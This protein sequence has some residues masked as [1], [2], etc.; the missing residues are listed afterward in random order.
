M[1]F[2]C[3]EASPTAIAVMGCTGGLLW[4][5]PGP[6][7]TV[8]LEKAQDPLFVENLSIFLAD[9][10]RAVFSHTMPETIKG[11]RGVPRQTDPADP[12]H[13]TGLLAGILHGIGHPDGA[14]YRIQKRVR[15]DVL[16]KDEG[17]PWRRSPLWLVLRVALQTT[18]RHNDICLYKAFMVFFMTEMVKRADAEHLDSD[19]LFLMNAKLGRR[20][21]KASTTLPDFVFEEAREVMLR[22]QQTL[23]NRWNGIQ[24]DQISTDRW[25]PKRLNWENDLILSLDKS[26]AYLGD[27][28]SRQLT[29]HAVGQFQPEEPPRLSV[30]SDIDEFGT[31]ENLPESGFQLYLLLGDFEKWVEHCLESWLTINIGCEAACQKVGDAIKQYASCARKAYKGSPENLS[32]M[33]L[34][35]LELWV[36]LDKAA[37]THC[38]LLDKYS[39]EIPDTLLEPLLLPKRSELERLH[40][41]E[42]YIRDRHRNA[43]KRPC[44]L[45]D[46]VN[47]QTFAIQ[48]WNQSLLHQK[49]QSLV[50]SEAATERAEKIQEYR[51]SEAT[52]FG[53]K[54]S[55]QGLACEYVT[56]VDRYDHPF[57]K[58]SETCRKCRLHQKADKMSI[59]PHRWPLPSN[60]MQKK[61]AIFELQC[62]LV[63][64]KWRDITYLILADFCSPTSKKCESTVF[65]NKNY[66]ELRRHCTDHNQRLNLASPK[67]FSKKRLRFP[68]LGGANSVCVE[69]GMVYSMYDTQIKNWVSESLQNWDIQPMSTLQLSSGPYQNMQYMVNDTS[70]TPNQVL[71][72]QHECPKDI[73]RQEYEA[74]GVLRAGHRLQWLNIARE[75]RARNLSWGNEAVAI[76]LMQAVWQAGPTI[77]TDTGERESHL[78][79]IDLE[80]AETLLSEIS[81]MWDLI[82]DNWREA[83]TAQSLLVLSARVL[84]LTTSESIKIRAADLMRRGREVTIR[85]VRQLAETLSQ[86][87]NSDDHMSDL[88]TRL[89]QVACICR[90]SYDV[91]QTDLARVLTLGADVEVAVEC[92][93]ILHDNSPLRYKSL[94]PLMR[95]LHDRNRCLGWRL[96]PRLRQLIMRVEVQEALNRCISRSWSKFN[97]GHRWETLSEPNDRWI[98]TRTNSSPERHVQLD[99]LTGRLL[100]DGLSLKR[101]PAEFT[102]HATYVRIFGK[103]RRLRALLKCINLLTCNSRGYSIAIQV[104]M[105]CSINLSRIYGGGRW[106]SITFSTCQT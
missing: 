90:I 2:E 56:N 89:Y 81:G 42:Q 50:E 48:F 39:P 23:Q 84:S 37:R 83:I 73:S 75:L 66:A 103:A 27:V 71:A 78:E 33:F 65:M 18:L 74:F 59:S 12:T 22:V 24:R 3:F 69:H 10:D 101:L 104:A 63:F 15:D 51:T 105:A 32:L 45:S 52:Y 85:W 44:I 91:D 31:L 34:T 43:E 26:R 77:S 11:S 8:S 30:S 82:S 86:G 95:S 38:A 96:Q 35:I 102:Q 25:E 88:H 62:P 47:N 28:V 61:V 7:F 58:H 92:A 4:T 16:W 98:V 20:V 99:I 60:D 40:K 53:L 13:I 46:V 64:C 57:Q 80:F 17:A 93:I 100:I 9:M 49:L 14:A 41:V 67:G 79:P 94:S 36:A 87:E 54:D 29:K 68:V 19:T 1:I 97:S 76:L 55:A 6:V 72:R 21:C 5:F 106:V 70:H